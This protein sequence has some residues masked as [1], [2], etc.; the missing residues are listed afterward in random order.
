MFLLTFEWVS[1]APHHLKRHHTVPIFLA[2]SLSYARS[3]RGGRLNLCI[4]SRRLYS[5]TP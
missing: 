3:I 4:P 1:R 2:L 5:V